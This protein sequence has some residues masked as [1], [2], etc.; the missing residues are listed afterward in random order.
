MNT[1]GTVNL[2]ADGLSVLLQPVVQSLQFW[3]ETPGSISAGSLVHSHIEIKH[4]R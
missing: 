3:T 1:S 2:A 4:E